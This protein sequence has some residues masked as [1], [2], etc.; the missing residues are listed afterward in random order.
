[1]R[2]SA[3]KVRLNCEQFAQNERKSPIYGTIKASR[4]SLLFFYPAH[5]LS[6]PGGLQLS[7]VFYTRSVMICGDGERII[8]DEGQKIRYR[9][10]SAVKNGP[11][12]R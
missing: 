10:F 9:G 4:G 2:T 3:D 5:L 1:M 8:P 6:F 7:G 12:P 11:H